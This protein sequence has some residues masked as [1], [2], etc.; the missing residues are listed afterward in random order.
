MAEFFAEGGFWMYPIALL[1]LVGVV[2]GAVGLGTR[3][4][5]VALGGLTCAA[6]VTV[7]GVAG[8]MSGRTQVDQALATV[9]PEDAELIR[10]V[11]YKEASRPL[12]LGGGFGM[13]GALLGVAAFTLGAR[14]RA[15]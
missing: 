5:S 2:L 7:L 1:G 14:E 12:Q 4:R 3:S 15:P 8:M 9:S 13:L 11:G 10:T 6:L